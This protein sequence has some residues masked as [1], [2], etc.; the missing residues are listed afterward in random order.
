MALAFLETR[1]LHHANKA[2]FQP[3]PGDTDLRNFRSYNPSHAPPHYSP[4]RRQSLECR[5]TRKSSC[6]G[7]YGVTYFFRQL[8][9]ST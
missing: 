5:V 2:G 9:D 3:M 4:D 7:E 1:P 8:S 6:Q